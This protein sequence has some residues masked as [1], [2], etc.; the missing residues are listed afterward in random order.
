M[1]GFSKIFIQRDYSYGTGVRFKEDFP[2]EL[3]DKVSLQP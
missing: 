3:K 1:S 2:E